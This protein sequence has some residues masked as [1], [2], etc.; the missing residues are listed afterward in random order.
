MQVPVSPFVLG[1]LNLEIDMNL[2]AFALRPPAPE[3]SI[4]RL[5]IDCDR[6]VLYV[7]PFRL[8]SMQ[9]IKKEGCLGKIAK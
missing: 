8:L 9:L 3:S 5:A 2:D 1:F 6:L 4:T 7:L